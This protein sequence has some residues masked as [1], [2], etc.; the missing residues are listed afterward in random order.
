MTIMK[1]MLSTCGRFVSSLLPLDVVC[2]LTFGRNGNDLFTN[3]SLALD[4]AR[5][6]FGASYIILYFVSDPLRFYHKSL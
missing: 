3:T 2:M 1:T 6:M 4:I 5:S